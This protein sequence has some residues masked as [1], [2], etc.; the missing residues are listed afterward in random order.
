MSVLVQRLMRS[1]L[2]RYTLA[3]LGREGRIT[4][5]VFVCCFCFVFFEEGGKVGMR[6]LGGKKEKMMVSQAADVSPLVWL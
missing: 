1:P 2:V 3:I 5:A 6:Y 4:M